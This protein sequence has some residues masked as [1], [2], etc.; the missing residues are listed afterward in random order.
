MTGE[1]ARQATVATELAFADEC[2]AESR[3][4]LEG[5]FLPSKPEA[6]ARGIRVGPA[7]AANSR[8]PRPRG[9]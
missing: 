6:P 1:E 8:L 9:W 2:L 3:F 5:G 7:K 4:A